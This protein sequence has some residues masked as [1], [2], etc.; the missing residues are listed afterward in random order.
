MKLA[1]ADEKEDCGVGKEVVADNE[2]K[3]PLQMPTKSH[4]V[5][6][7]AQIEKCKQLFDSRVLSKKNSGKLR[8]L[9]IA[10]LSGS[11]DMFAETSVWLSELLWH[12]C[13]SRQLCFQSVR[14]FGK[15]P[16]PGLEPGSL[17]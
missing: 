17:G 3:P 1:A 15:I 2:S 9:R 7:H 12:G 16:P 10:Q 5:R 4:V 6:P 8:N 14:S 11:C 13:T